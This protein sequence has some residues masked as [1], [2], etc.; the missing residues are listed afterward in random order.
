MGEKELTFHL[1]QVAHPPRVEGAVT[2][3]REGRCQSLRRA[4]PHRLHR[5]GRATE[6]L[7]SCSA[8][9]GIAQLVVPPSSSG[10]GYQTFDLETR[11]RVPAGVPLT[12]KEDQ[13]MLAAFTLQDVGVLMFSGGLVLL[14]AVIILIGKHPDWF[15]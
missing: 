4:A 10:L 1:H 5:S 6:W 15:R 7:W 14:G 8:L 9:F 3:F 13:T 11:V 2:P 12:I